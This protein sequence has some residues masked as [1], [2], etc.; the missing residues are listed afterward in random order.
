MPRKIGRELIREDRLLR[1]EQFDPGHLE[2]HRLGR[3]RLPWFGFLP[4]LLLDLA[5]LEILPGLM[6]AALNPLLTSLGLALLCHPLDIGIARFGQRVFGRG[7]L[8]A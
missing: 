4:H 2:S 6:P 8:L 1:V 3:K 5:K 7:S